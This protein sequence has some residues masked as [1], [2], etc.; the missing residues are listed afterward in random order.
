MHRIALSRW[1]YVTKA[2]PKECRQRSHTRHNPL[3]ESHRTIHETGEHHNSYSQRQRTWSN[4]MSWRKHKITQFEPT[5]QYYTLRNNVDAANED[6]HS[7]TTK[8]KGDKMEG[9]YAI[10]EVLQ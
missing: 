7:R 4:V 1:A 9:E 8:W 2:Q 10:I 3:H 6:S 5:E